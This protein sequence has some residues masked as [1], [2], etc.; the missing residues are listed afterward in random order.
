MPLVAFRR[1]LEKSCVAFADLPEVMPELMSV[2]NLVRVAI[3]STVPKSIS[4]TTVE[5]ISVFY[6]YWV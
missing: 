3:G 6:L 5:V 1:Y 2:W 4:G